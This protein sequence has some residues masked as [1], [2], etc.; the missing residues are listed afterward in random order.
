MKGGMLGWARRRR[1]RHAWMGRPL[2]TAATFAA[3]SVIF[4]WCF[5]AE[6]APAPESQRSSPAHHQTLTSGQ[7]RAVTAQSGA[8][9]PALGRHKPAQ[10]SSKARPPTSKEGNRVPAARSVLRGRRC[11]N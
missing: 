6:G 5:A 2:A 10:A 9:R 3:Q 1:R 11:A 7:T 4:T 8:L